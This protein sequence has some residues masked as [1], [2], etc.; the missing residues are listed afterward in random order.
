MHTHPLVSGRDNILLWR[1]FKACHFCSTMNRADVAELVVYAL[2]LVVAFCYLIS[3]VSNA[4][5][6]QCINYWNCARHLRSASIGPWNY[7]IDL[8]DGQWREFRNS[9]P[10]LIGACLLTCAASSLLRLALRKWKAN[11]RQRAELLLRLAVGVVV[12]TVQHGY[13]SVIIISIALMGY[14][15]TTV[16]AGGWEPALTWL[17]AIAVLLFKESYRVKHLTRFSFLAPLFDRRYGGMYGWQLPANFLVLRIISFSLDMYWAQNSVSRNKKG[18]DSSSAAAPHGDSTAADDSALPTESYSLLHYM[19]YILYAPL[20]MAGPIITFNAFVRCLAPPT[21]LIKRP[22]TCEVDKIQE[23]AGSA[24][25]SS[26]NA[27]RPASENV[28]LY[29]VRWLACLALMEYLLHRCPFFAVAA[30]GLLNRLTPAQTAVTS[31][32]LLKLM[33][34]KFLLLWR[35]FRLWAMLDGV[36][37]PENMTR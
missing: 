33:W 13:H 9:L 29:L 14:L 2:N 11:A 8:A 19:A 17:Y 36:T 21:E 4:I 31:Y 27:P 28:W 3:G 12:L 23:P 1:W 37:P 7:A 34:L 35:F 5:G 30:S 15:V 18:D 22:D 32:L 10:I 6:E 24:H 20:Y 25:T 26:G 16:K